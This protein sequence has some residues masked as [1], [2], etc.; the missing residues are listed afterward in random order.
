[1]LTLWN[2]H[3]SRNPLLEN[4]SKDVALKLEDYQKTT[5]F[6]GIFVL[7]LHFLCFLVTILIS[8][9]DVQISLKFGFVDLPDSQQSW[10]TFALNDSTFSGNIDQWITSDRVRIATGVLAWI[11]YA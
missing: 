5:L 11:G 2:S 10:T 6:I 9:I 3:T 1:V 7:L 8:F 4:L